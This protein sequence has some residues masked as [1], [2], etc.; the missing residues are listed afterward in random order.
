MTNIKDDQG[1]DWAGNKRTQEL[2]VDTFL[3]VCE[4]EGLAPVDIVG[5]AETVLV[6]MIADIAIDLPAALEGLKACVSDM[7]IT[8]RQRFSTT[9]TQ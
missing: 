7:E 2:L 3:A 4:K 5:C 6:N 1:R 9:K 8:L